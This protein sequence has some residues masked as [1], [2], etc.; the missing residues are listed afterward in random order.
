MLV[1]GP[2]IRWR[3]PS[4]SGRDRFMTFRILIVDDH[5]LLRDG[6]R[7]LLDAEEEFEVVGEAE[8]GREALS[9]AETL[10]PDLILMDIGMRDL[11]G[12]EA[13]RQLKAAYPE[14]GI[15]GL[16]T[17]SDKRYVLGML[18]AGASGYVLKDSAYDEV[19]RAMH[20]VGRGKTYLS[21]DVAGV[22]VEK[23]LSEPS[24]AEAIASE[25]TPREREVVQ[26][27]AEGLGAG[28]IG[29][30]LHISSSTVDS[31]RKNVMAKLDLKS[32]AELTKYAVRAGLTSLER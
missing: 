24:E 12:V 26:L 6:L 15:V 13:T 10:R 21:S 9:L 17:H 7:S 8:T 29:E 30:R 31:H 5:H 22:V 28:A 19:R 11:N 23:S 25:L 1:T 3:P 4:G 27:I 14:I 32:V 20:A 18:E 16:S 2:E